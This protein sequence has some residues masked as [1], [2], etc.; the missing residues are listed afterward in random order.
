[1]WLANIFLSLCF[2]ELFAKQSLFHIKKEKEPTFTNMSINFM[3]NYDFTVNKQNIIQ[4]ENFLI[5]LENSLKL[6][7]AHELMELCI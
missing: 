4:L 6:Y 2:S 3:G 5:Q 1:M 7:S